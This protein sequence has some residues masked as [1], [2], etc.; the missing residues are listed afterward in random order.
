ML[1]QQDQQQRLR[2]FANP[3]YGYR[4]GEDGEI[5]KDL[6]DGELPEGWFDSPADVDGEPEAAP[7][8]L[9]VADAD[10]LVPPYDQ[11][12]FGQ[13]RAEYERRVGKGPPVGTST[14]DLVMALSDMDAG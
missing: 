9:G 8:T 2:E 11:Y 10:H 5:E 3:T 12:S 4:R 7:K 13:L 14:A 6:F 1:T